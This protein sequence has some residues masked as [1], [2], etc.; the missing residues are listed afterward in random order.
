MPLPWW[1]RIILRLLRPFVAVDH[2][3]FIM[4]G[5]RRYA[6][7]LGCDIANGHRKGLE[8]LL[9][10]V[11]FCN[12]LGIKTVT[13][14]ALSLQNYRRTHQEIKDLLSIAFEAVNNRGSL[15]EFAKSESC[16]VKFCG[17]FRFI[18]DELKEN[19]KKLEKETEIFDRISLNICMSYGARNEISRALECTEKTKDA[20]YVCDLVL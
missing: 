17:D 1:T 7:H 15:E 11:S 6:R 19:L 5:N 16:Q 3:A 8:K 14:Y 12:A 9:E 10:V 18:G 2:V 13:V 4:D 20:G